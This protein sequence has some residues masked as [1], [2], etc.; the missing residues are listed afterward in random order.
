M[1][2]KIILVAGFGLVMAGTAPTLVQDY[3]SV[4]L[5]QVS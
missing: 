3:T 1:R 4:S 2:F 5:T